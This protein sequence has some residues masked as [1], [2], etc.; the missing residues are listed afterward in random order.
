MSTTLSDYQV[1]GHENAQMLPAYGA[2]PLGTDRLKTVPGTA[3]QSLVLGTN[4]LR[5]LQ[6]LTE[7]KFGGNTAV[8]TVHDTAGDVLNPSNLV[9]DDP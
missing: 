6:R 5:L 7:T 8:P 1:S 4:G 9:D 2:W 3:E